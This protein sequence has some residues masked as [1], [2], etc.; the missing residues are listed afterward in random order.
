[1]ISTSRVLRLGSPLARFGVKLVFSLVFFPT[2]FYYVN[3]Q[4]SRAN[5]L[6]ISILTIMVNSTTTMMGNNVAKSTAKPLDLGQL[7][8]PFALL[9][10]FALF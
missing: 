3:A 9:W 6:Y 8:Q 7:F 5:I 4:E 10:G 1:M 2:S